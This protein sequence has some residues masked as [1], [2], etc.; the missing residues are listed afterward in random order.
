MVG[1]S[2][3]AQPVNPIITSR[4]IFFPPRFGMVLRIISPVF[5]MLAERCIH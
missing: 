1:A 2:A 3:K 5:A 4:F